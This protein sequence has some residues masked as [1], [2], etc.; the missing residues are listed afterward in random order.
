MK[1][2]LLD[3][4]LPVACVASLAVACTNT[5]DTV[6]TL[7]GLG[8]TNIETHGYSPTMCGKDGTCTKFTAV[9]AQGRT[10]RGAVGCSRMGCGKGCTVRFD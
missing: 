1:R 9:N 5:E 2:F 3:I 4:I 8:F 10:V 7:E 6:R